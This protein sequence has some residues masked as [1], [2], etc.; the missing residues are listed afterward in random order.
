MA[1]EKELEKIDSKK[2]TVKTSTP[3]E[4]KPMEPKEPVI[5]S[6][7]QLRQERRDKKATNMVQSDASRY[8]I[9]L[10]SISKRPLTDTDK[11]DFEES[12]KKMASKDIVESVTGYIDSYGKAPQEKEPEL[13]QKEL[14]R[15][16]KQQRKARWGD[17]LYAFG[18]GLQ[19][20]TA[21]PEAMATTRLQRQRD[22]MFQEYKDVTTRNQKAREL[23]NAQRNNEMLKWLTEK[24]ND[25]NLT[26]SEKEKYRLMEEELKL[27]NRQTDLDEEELKARKSGQYYQ[28][29]TTQQQTMQLEDGTW[30]LSN[31]NPHTSLF[32]KQGGTPYLINKI[33][34]LQGGDPNK[35]PSPEDAE[36]ISNLLIENMFNIGQDENGNLYAEPIPGTENYLKDFEKA[37]TGLEGLQTEISNL[38]YELDYAKRRQKPMIEQ[39]ISAKKQELAEQQSKVQSF[40]TGGYNP[41]TQSKLEEFFGN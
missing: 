14:E 8:G 30:Q 19:G 2:A 15:L 5:K 7:K 29:R 21:N 25:A 26:A 12:V 38:E 1:K 41:E 34:G 3:E 33:S 6:P 10:K 24:Q 22:N 27:R 31:R 28:P 9:D 11:K 23:W 37:I 40:L 17:A 35:A 4:L 32:Y 20:R 16:A 39:Q 18:E 13:N 36:R